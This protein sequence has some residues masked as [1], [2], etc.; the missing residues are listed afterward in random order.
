MRITIGGSFNVNTVEDGAQGLPVPQYHEQAYA[1][2][3]EADTGSS[4]VAPSDAVWTA[5]IPAKQGAKIYLWLRDRTMTWVNNAYVAGTYTFTRINGEN[6]TGVRIKGSF[7]DADIAGYASIPDYLSSVHPNPEIGDGYTYEEDGH[8]WLW[9][10]TIWQ[11]VGQIKGDNGLSSYLHIA[12]AHAVGSQ[13][14]P[15]PGMGF[16]TVKAAD[17]SYEYMGVYADNEPNDST[18]PSDYE[19][20]EVKGDG[21]V[22]LDLD[23]E[24]DTMLYDGAGNLVSG[25]VTSNATLYIGGDVISSGVTYSI[26]SSSGMNESQRSVT[27]S[28]VVTVSGMTA[29]TG[30]VMVKASYEQHDYFA[31][32]TLKRLVNADKYDLVVRPSA[33]SFNTTTLTPANTA[34]TINIMRFKVDGTKEAV[35]ALLASQTLKAYG[36]YN[37][38]RTEVT[39]SHSSGSANWTLN[40]NNA[41]YTEY[42]IELKDG[43]DFLD[44]ETIPINRVANGD[45]GV[46]GKN[47]VILD[48]TNEMDALQYDDAGKVNSSDYVETTA[49]LLDGGVDKTADVSAWNIT[50]SS[51]C[52][53]S[54]DGT[55]FRFRVTAVTGD[56]GTVTIT[57]TYKGL[58]Y[59]AVFTVKRL[60]NK[61]KYEL[62][63]SPN[64]VSYNTTDSEASASSLVI[65]VYRTSNGVRTLV[66]SLQTY[67]LK[68]YQAVSTSGTEGIPSAITSSYTNGRC[69]INTI[70]YNADYYRFILTDGDNTTNI[71]D[72][73]TVPISK[74]ENGDAGNDAF[75]G[76]LS[77]E[78]DS[79][80]M[81]CDGYTLSSSQLG[82]K[83]TLY[84]GTTPQTLTNLVVD[85]SSFP[86][87]VTATATKGTGIVQVTIPQNTTL[88]GDRL[89][90]PITATCAY[91]SKALLFT[92]TG[93]RAGEAGAS[94]VIYQL[95]P[96]ANEIK[97]D[98]NGTYSP[99]TLSCTQQSVTGNNAPVP[100]TAKSM[101][102]AI[103]DGAESSYTSGANVQNLT[104]ARKYVTF[105][106]KDGNKQL[107]IETIPVVFDGTDGDNSVRLDLSNEMDSIIYDEKGN[108]MSGT[109]LTEARLYDGDTIVDPTQTSV[110]TFTHTATN[111]TASE[112]S[113]NSERV[114]YAVSG[115]TSGYA[116]GSL[117][118][119]A[120]YKGKDY[121][122]ALTVKRLV[123][124]DKY[125][126]HVTPSAVT[127]N[128]TTGV[129]NASS[130]VVKIYKTSATDGNRT[131]VTALSNSLRLWYK[132]INSSGSEPDRGTRVTSAYGSNGFTLSTLDFSNSGYRFYID[133][134]TTDNILDSETV[135]LASVTNGANGQNGQNGADAYYADLTNEMD[136]IALDNS[137]SIAANVSVQTEMRVYKGSTPQTLSVVC[138]KDEDAD[139]GITITYD[140]NNTV[141]IIEADFPAG[142][143]L[144]DGDVLP[145]TCTATSGGKTYTKILS[146]TGIRAGGI[147][148][149]AVIYQLVPFDNTIKVS[150]TGSRTPQTLTCTISKRIG[151]NEATPAPSSDNCIIK[152]LID[153]RNEQ[154]YPSS[155]VP[156][157]GANQ[158]ISFKLYQGTGTL[159]HLDTETIPVL[160]D[161]EDGEDGQDATIYQIQMETATAYVDA[162]KV[163]HGNVSWR[164]LKV[165]GET[166]Q[167]V[168]WTDAT[169]ARYQVRIDNGTWTNAA[170]NGSDNSL[171]TLPNNFFDGKT[172]SSSFSPKVIAIRYLDENNK[173]L[174]THHVQVTVYGERG[175]SGGSAIYVDLDNETDSL[176]YKD[177]RTKLVAND[178]VTST[179]TLYVG[180]SPT[181]SGVT[182]AQVASGVTI[183]SQSTSN[184]ITVTGVSGMSGYVTITATY[185][186]VSYNKVFT[187]KKLINEDK[188]QLHVE[189]INVTYNATDEEYSNNTVS[190]R[191][192]KYSVDGTSS[193]IQTIPSTYKLQQ[194]TITTSNGTYTSTDADVSSSYA[195]GVYTL[196]LPSSIGN[197]TSYEFALI[198]KSDSF[199]ADNETVSI[200]QVENGDKGDDAVVY[201]A[202]TTIE[203]IK[204]A[205]GATSAT[206]S[207]TAR[208]YKTTGATKAAYSAYAALYKR[209]GT[210]YEYIHRTDAKATTYSVPTSPAVTV[211]NEYDAIVVFFGDSKFSTSSTLPSSYVSK[212]ELLIWQEASSAL[213]IDLTNEMGSVPLDP[214]N[215]WSK[216][217]INIETYVKMYLGT[218]PQTITAMTVDLSDAPSGVTQTHTLS[219]G[220]VKITIP[221]HTEFANQTFSVPITAT[222]AKGSRTAT[223][224]VMGN[225]EGQVGDAATIY[226][227]EPSSDAIKVDKDGEYFPNVLSCKVRRTS[228]SHVTYISNITLKYTIDDVAESSA[229]TIA[230]NTNISN[231]TSATKRVVFYCYS[232]SNVL[233]DKE[234]V[235]IVADGIDVVSYRIDTTTQQI[236][237]PEGATSYSL[238]A[239]LSFFKCLG[240]TKNAY[241]AF[242][243]AWLKKGDNY[244]YLT[245]NTTKSTTFNFSNYALSN[246]TNY[247]CLT[248]FI[249]D[250]SF[251]ATNRTTS[252]LPVH[253]ARLDIPIIANG[254]NAI[255]ADITNQMDA[256]SCDTDGKVLFQRT[257][258]LTASVYDGAN[259]GQSIGLTTTRAQLAIGGVQPTI[260]E[261]QLDNKVVSFGISWT[262][263]V[264]T[265]ISSSVT[266]TI[267]MTY[268]G[269]SYSADF[270]LNV[271]HESTIYQLAI[272][273]SS[274]S[275]SRVNGGT[276]FTPTNYE[277]VTNVFKHTTAGT[278]EIS[279]DID[280]LLVYY[281]FNGN[282]NNYQQIGDY[283]V[284]A[285]YM[286]ISGRTEIRDVTVE[287]WKVTWNDNVPTKVG[288]R[289]DIQTLSVN[290][291][292]QNGQNGQ[293]GADAVTYQ[294]AVTDSTLV[295]SANGRLSGE[296]NWNVYKYTGAT[297]QQMEGYT[298]EF[299]LNS[300]S[301][302][303]STTG[304]VGDYGTEQEYYNIPVGSTTSIL[305]IRAYIGTSV[306]ATAQVPITIK[307]KMGRN[308]YFAGEYSASATYTTTDFEAPYVSLTEN[309]L[310]TYWVRVGENGS[311]TNQIPSSSSIYW[312]KMNAEFKYIITEAIFTQF[313]KLGSAI[314]NQDYMY[315]QYGFMRGFG[316]EQV[317]VNDSTQYQYID[318]TD[319]NGDDM[320]SNKIW[321]KST[322]T[323]VPDSSW[324]KLNTTAANLISGRYYTL[325][326]SGNPGLDGEDIGYKISKTSSGAALV[327]GNIDYGGADD[328]YPTSY[329]VFRCTSDG[330]YNLYANSSSDDACVVSSFYLREAKFVPA[331]YLNF[332]NGEMVANKL[333]ARG[334]LY[335]ASVN[336]DTVVAQ[337][338]AN[339]SNDVWVKDNAVVALTSLNGTYPVRVI[340][341]DEDKSEGRRVELFAYKMGSFRVT[342]IKNGNVVSGTSTILLPDGSTGYRIDQNWTNVSHAIFHCIDGHWRVM[343]REIVLQSS[344][345]YMMINDLMGRMP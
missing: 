318:P 28:G 171:L 189:P 228:G 79:V 38:A 165:E 108:K 146:I 183:S 187:V 327:N 190:V 65:N 155:G 174:A 208:S 4:T 306:V 316:G 256:V 73:E 272:E 224:V 225:L 153:G 91:G 83:A 133:N 266:K 237:V 97:V 310:I 267:T 200:A 48:L 15:E 74:V 182:W 232:A 33:I 278:E 330:N 31:K 210:T 127:R 45:E 299:K 178:S 14:Y 103:D 321:D 343:L 170:V 52:T 140:A 226:D 132:A 166:A 259:K 81:D 35:T 269:V 265:V 144:L 87:G 320:E 279:S 129:Q 102:V 148:Q 203:N 26:Y 120:T 60:L 150:Q 251:S 257:I 88:S 319:I 136:S 42:V 263:P 124:I 191:V 135:P 214:D 209:K 138:T 241:S 93:V 18:T 312:T 25:N 95:V 40:T 221:I 34:I 206:V 112:S 230:V 281:G 195:N 22:K 328:V 168:T 54:R 233:L 121:Y 247:E 315:S 139:C 78:M 184:V 340:L 109:I 250:I 215:E 295:V 20:V 258:S 147:G 331:L 332:L 304:N 291:D 323:T 302:W 77:N 67:G 85:T 172:Y 16:T 84:L 63:V 10:G 157:S 188:Y 341:P 131:L 344:G 149:D 163:C 47:S 130:I 117:T 243:G 137:G 39:I 219:N 100:T 94:P 292:G 244:T 185:G 161:G 276:T 309:G 5:Y 37:S 43:N 313:A 342:F 111:I 246:V 92:I 217:A 107:D 236:V 202:E 268:K 57:A 287:L 128:A 326:I 245:R 334:N 44:S 322:D 223:L 154:E 29:V 325:E 296:A 99:S 72:T 196:T 68:L 216:V 274:L 101:T 277:V 9:N 80:G 205:E 264:G 53:A 62:K 156:T 336:Y 199:L 30:F 110:V 289:L 113:K 229:Q 55:S 261:L 162:S 317:E 106:L 180:G 142:G 159:K 61:P 301:A 167:Y 8:M 235:P 24:N 242:F 70:N 71:H 192:W 49:V 64:S 66:P 181:T 27:S 298:C 238:S 96:S 17:E 123:N 141:A 116:E 1:W 160:Y 286:T 151:N 329:H 303:H 231:L 114:V 305:D 12:W 253:I 126:L 311:I 69:P 290:K 308:Y 204:I 175:P 3:S 288:D 271:S 220:Y 164:V 179:A 82:T 2:S 152:Y 252:T 50:A 294:I 173:E 227:L 13:G 293:N 300:E 143:N 273:P 262:F 169:K 198:R 248:L 32:L 282:A 234:T 158:N 193:N 41:A 11:D 118:V 104:T 115:I 134:G 324:N 297:R 339:I 260:Q 186:G 76:D 280:G 249:G 119:K 207:F 337:A 240:E 6:G 7:S 51:G 75:Y 255:R 125:D 212:K 345:N 19:W 105:R 211:T 333:T 86:Q 275:F 270:T 239:N 23:N 177:D 335:A 285:P 254:S 36:V 218:E 56:G 338:S 307:G 197:I 59:E 46:A 176:Q 90:V 145:I 201:S 58:P 89:E 283:F 194:T 98:K 222:C 314:F 21:N 213:T 122:A 284:V